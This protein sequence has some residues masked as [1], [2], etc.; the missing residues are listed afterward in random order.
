MNKSVM[1][2]INLCTAGVWNPRKDHLAMISMNVIRS[3]KFTSSSEQ[4]IVLIL[5][6]Y[7]LLQFTTTFFM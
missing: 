6:T 4:S 5:L 2:I 1:F 3:I 7:I